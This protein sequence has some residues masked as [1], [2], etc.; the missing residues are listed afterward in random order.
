MSDQGSP[1]TVL[2]MEQPQWPD[3]RFEWHPG[4]ER[5][6]VIRVGVKPMMGDPIAFDIEDAK[7]AKDSVT[8]WLRGYTAAKHELAE[9]MHVEPPE[10]KVLL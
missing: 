6:Y 5:V 9:V 8:Q 3:F 4:A 7:S 1:K 10:A 2:V